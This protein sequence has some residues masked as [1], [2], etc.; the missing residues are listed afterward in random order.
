M[1]SDPK[2]DDPFK[3]APVKITSNGPRTDR[4]KL[5]SALVRIGELNEQ[6]EDSRNQHLRANIDAL[7][8]AAQYSRLK[9]QLKDICYWI[10]SEW[11][12]G[13]PP[14]QSMNKALELDNKHNWNLQQEH[15]V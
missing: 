5:D 2:S 13:I 8:L 15:D 9:E 12:Q 11:K 4:Q 10:M 7:E 3:P 1:N 6:L 14:D